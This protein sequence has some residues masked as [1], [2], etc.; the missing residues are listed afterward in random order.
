MNLLKNPLIRIIGIIAILY[1][2]LFSNTY[3]KESLGNRLSKDQV[4]KDLSDAKEKG[5]QII[6]HVK[7]AQE[8]KEYN[9]TQNTSPA[10]DSSNL[11]LKDI[12]VGE[13]LVA[14]CGDSAVIAYKLFSGDQLIDQIEKQNLVIGE[15]KINYII[16]SSLI[17]FNVGGA[18]VINIPEGYKF[19]DPILAQSLS[20]KKD[21]HYEINLLAIKKPTNSTPQNCNF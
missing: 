7:K 21:L 3:E 8:L 15:R 20:G 1:V 17:G 4:Q 19:K 12:K 16:E 2:G 11:N 14:A 13:G 5:F 10:I 6:N 18:R 9:V